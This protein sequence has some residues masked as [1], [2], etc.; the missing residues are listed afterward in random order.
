[1]TIPMALNDL[2]LSLYNENIHIIFQ[3]EKMPK[4]LSMDN[5]KCI[6]SKR[7][8][9]YKDIELCCSICPNGWTT[10]DKGKVI[11]YLERKAIPQNIKSITFIC[12]MACPQT[13][14]QYQMTK[15][16]EI[17]KLTALFKWHPNLLLLTDCHGHNELEFIC[18][19]DILNIQYDNGTEYHKQGIIMNKQSELSWDLSD[20]NW[21]KLNFLNGP[22]LSNIWN[23]SLQK[24]V[25]SSG[26]I[27]D[28]YWLNIDL[29]QWPQ[30]I[31]EVF[32]E[33][34]VTLDYEESPQ[35]IHREEQR[36]YVLDTKYHGLDFPRLNEYRQ[37]QRARIKEY[38][39]KICELKDKDNNFIDKSKWKEFNVLD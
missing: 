21:S 6:Y 39:L 22:S 35:Q 10:K 13:N 1:M 14:T 38:P 27:V 16:K 26:I 17:S 4:F 15:K 19:V 2:C 31:K 8:I 29:I 20:F 28:Q 5:H 32:A 9:K 37:G 30:N 25:I 3:S 7:V 34:I 11:F 33:Y 24:E 18:N 12:K 23:I 36:K